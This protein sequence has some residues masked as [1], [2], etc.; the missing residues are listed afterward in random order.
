[1]SGSQSQGYA[2][3]RLRQ[4][5]ALGNEGQGVETP[6]LPPTLGPPAQWDVG[7]CPSSLPSTTPA[8]FLP[9]N[10]PPHLMA[11]NLC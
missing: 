6:A 8:S 5:C 7:L 4:G 9:R 1:M 3:S 2:A 10:Y 11:P